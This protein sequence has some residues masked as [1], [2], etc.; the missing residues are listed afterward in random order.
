MFGRDDNEYIRPSEE[1]LADCGVDDCHTNHDYT[2]PGTSPYDTAEIESEMIGLL[3]SGER[4]LWCGKADKNAPKESRKES[5][6]GI[7]MAV[8]WIVFSA[9]WTIGTGIGT[10]GMAVVV[11]IPFIVIGIFLLKAAIKRSKQEILYAITDQRVIVK[12]EKGNAFHTLRDI[13]ESSV[14][15]CKNGYGFITFNMKGAVAQLPTA[16]G[17]YTLAGADT[18]VTLFALKDP[19]SVYNILRSAI[20]SAKTGGRGE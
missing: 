8:F 14:N 16:K 12:S 18:S 15:E 5:T 6:S 3:K 2:A 7:G 10:G 19:K 20:I 13:R 9:L 17:N 1:Y 11:G 4:I